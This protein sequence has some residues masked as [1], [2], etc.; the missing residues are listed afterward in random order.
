M[1]VAVHQ[2]NY[3]PWIGYFHKMANADIFVLLDTVQLPRGSSVANRSQIKSAGGALQLTVPLSIPKG[4]RGK[5]SYAEAQTAGGHWKRQHLKSIRMAYGRAPYFE[6]YFGQLERIL[7]DEVSF[8]E[9][10]KRFISSCAKELGLSAEIV[11]LSEMPGTRGAKSELIVSICRQLGADT[12]LSGQGAR[13][14]ND[15]RLFADA[16]LRLAYQEFRCPVYTQLHGEFMPN[17]SIIDLLFN[18]GPGG[19]EIIERG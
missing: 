3:L 8:V 19:R 9:I 17:L 10:N 6:M 15:E 18:Q 13:K 5:V 14:Y 7:G 1:I 16:G 2:P 12:Y 11:L 4:R